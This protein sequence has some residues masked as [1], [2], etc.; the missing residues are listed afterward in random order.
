VSWTESE[1]VAALEGER[2]LFAWC[3][4][5][6][7]GISND[8]AAKQALVRY[9]YEAADQPFRELVFHDTSWH[10]AMVHLNGDGYWRAHRELEQPSREYEEVRRRVFGRGR[11]L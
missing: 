8:A 4:E 1:Y 10:F 3:L 2:H 11:S 9:P 5:R 7:G 6:Y